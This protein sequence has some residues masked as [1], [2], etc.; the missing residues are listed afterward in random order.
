MVSDDDKFTDHL[1]SSSM[2]TVNCVTQIIIILKIP[3]EI[4]H[5]RQF[6]P[7]STFSFPFHPLSPPRTLIIILNLSSP[8]TISVDIFQLLFISSCTIVTILHLRLTVQPSDDH[9]NHLRHH[10]QNIILHLRSSYRPPSTVHCHQP[11][12][13]LHRSPSS[14]DSNY[15]LS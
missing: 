10:V 5:L 8:V 6:H 7:S 3:S 12:P 14:L 2:S 9:H 15:P 1:L 4:K 11:P 13:S